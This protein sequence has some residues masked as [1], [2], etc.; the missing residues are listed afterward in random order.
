MFRGL[1]QATNTRAA[2]IVSMT[3]GAMKKYL[4]D[5]IAKIRTTGNEYE[6]TL[7]ASSRGA[8]NKFLGMG[9][10]RTARTSPEIIMSSPATTVRCCV[11]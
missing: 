1:R 9:L 10:P 11:R 2:I 8:Y 7:L 4:P 6:R 3:I 5:V